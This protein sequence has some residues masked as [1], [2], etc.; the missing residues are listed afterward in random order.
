MLHLS[1]FGK[2]QRLS[3]TTTEILSNLTWFTWDGAGIFLPQAA[4]DTP[5][6]MRN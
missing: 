2:L 3:R 4:L 1:R 5:A 6:A